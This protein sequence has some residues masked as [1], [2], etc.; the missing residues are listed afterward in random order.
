M[1]TKAGVATLRYILTIFWK[2]DENTNSTSQ[3]DLRV[4]AK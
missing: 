3:L 1:E 2:R 4:K